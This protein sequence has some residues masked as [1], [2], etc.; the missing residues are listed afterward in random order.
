[1]NNKM[2]CTLM[3]L[4]GG[5]RGGVCR[6]RNK[7]RSYLTIYYQKETFLS[8]LFFFFLTLFCTIACMMAICSTEE[9]ILSHSESIDKG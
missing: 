8:Y 9:R 2:L 5:Y 4:R 6:G 7:K 1:M 3:A